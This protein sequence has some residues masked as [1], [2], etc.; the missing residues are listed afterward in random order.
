MWRERIEVRG[1]IPAYIKPPAFS[2]S[3]TICWT[4]LIKH[5]LTAHQICL[6]LLFKPY[7]STIALLKCGG[8]ALRQDYL[9]IEARK[10]LFEGVCSSFSSRNSMLSM[11]F[12][13]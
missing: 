10:C 12:R 2:M 4:C 7:I 1:G 5:L 9:L 3:M 8:K 6:F 11:G 13:G